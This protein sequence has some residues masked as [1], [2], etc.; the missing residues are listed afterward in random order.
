MVLADQIKTLRTFTHASHL[1]SMQFSIIDQLLK[2][3]EPR[4]SEMEEEDVICAMQAFEFINIQKSFTAKKLF[5]SLTDT[6]SSL[7]LEN[8]SMVELG[9]LTNY[10]S[11]FFNSNY[12]TYSTTRNLSNFGELIQLLEKK[13]VAAQNVESYSPRLIDRLSKILLLEKKSQVLADTI[14]MYMETQARR[15]QYFET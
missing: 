1:L 6:V 14:Q 4:I 15:M 12:L 11:S 10:L 3:I 8:A 5:T 13:I 2:K 9:F 7:A